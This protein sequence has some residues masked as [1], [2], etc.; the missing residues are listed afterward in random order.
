[1]WVIGDGFFVIFKVVDGMFLDYACV[2]LL[3][4]K[5]IMKVDVKEFFVVFGSVVVVVDV[6]LKVVKLFVLGDE[7]LFSGCG[8]VGEVVSVVF[9]EY[10][11][12]LLDI[13]FNLI[14]IVDFMVQV[15]GGV[16]SLGLSGF[17]DVVLVKFDECFEFVGVFMLC[18]M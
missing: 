9:V 14:Y 2:F 3:F 6:W 12:D 11:G 10:D 18:R 8:D 7:C 16:V 13:G 5:V 1:M 4:I 17:M 15:E